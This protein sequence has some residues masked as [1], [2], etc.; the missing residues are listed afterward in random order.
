MDREDFRPR[1][2]AREGFSWRQ[3]FATVVA[4]AGAVGSSTSV[5]VRALDVGFM[6]VRHFEARLSEIEHRLDRVEIGQA[7]NR[8]DVVLVRAEIEGIKNKAK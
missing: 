2:R 1:Y 3:F 8:S 7:E 6:Q 4:V 5:I